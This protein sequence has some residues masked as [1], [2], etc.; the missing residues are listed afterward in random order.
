MRRIL[1]SVILMIFLTVSV[2]SLWIMI[3]NVGQLV[4]AVVWNLGLM[5]KIIEILMMGK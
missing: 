5:L 2:I 1:L 3:N 4:V